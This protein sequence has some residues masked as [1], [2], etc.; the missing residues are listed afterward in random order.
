MPNPYPVAHL[1]LRYA[2]PF[3][4]LRKAVRIEDHLV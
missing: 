1:M 4:L 3:D 2:F